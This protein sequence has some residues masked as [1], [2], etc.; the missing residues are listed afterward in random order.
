MTIKGRGL[1]ERHEFEY[2]IPPGDAVQL[3][4]LCAT[5]LC[6]KRYRLGRWEVDHFADRGLWLAEIELS[7]ADEPFERP[8]WLREE[9]SDDPR[10]QN[11]NLARPN[12]SL[13][14]SAGGRGA[15]PHA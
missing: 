14:P 6:K 13:G 12:G 8:A 15:A 2:P 1:I 3:L 5:S 4:N 9:V 7:R 10:Y 11:V